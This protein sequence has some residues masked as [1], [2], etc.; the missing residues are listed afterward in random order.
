ME[1]WTLEQLMQIEQFPQDIIDLA[2]RKLKERSDVKN[3]FAWFMSVCRSEVAKKNALPSRDAEAQPAFGRKQYSQNGKAG[4]RSSHASSTSVQQAKFR[5]EEQYQQ[6]SKAR[7]ERKHNDPE[8]FASNS[9]PK[10]TLHEFALNYER[11]IHQRTLTDS[12]LAAKTSRFDAN[13]VWRLLT[14]QE[15]QDIWNQAHGSCSCRK[16]YESGVLL[17][18][19]ARQ[20]YTEE[21]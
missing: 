4:A 10:E 8:R 3:S 6:W 20:L 13:P 5:S 17:P 12:S 18:E 21:A 9:K 14:E 15:R 16:N 2:H 19:I 7:N 1:Q 11:L